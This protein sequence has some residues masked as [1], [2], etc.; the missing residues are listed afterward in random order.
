MQSTSLK[1]PTKAEKARFAHFSR[2][3]CIA[4][5]LAG[6]TDCGP[7]E[8]HHLLSGNKRRGHAYSIPLGSHHHR[9]E[10]PEGMTAKQAAEWYGPSLARQ[11]KAFRALYGSDD[12]LLA[13]VNRRIEA[14]T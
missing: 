7:T 6:Q 5:R 2:I 11:S 13:E 3:G 12:V 9:G 10:P 4:C 8:A 1:A 14:M